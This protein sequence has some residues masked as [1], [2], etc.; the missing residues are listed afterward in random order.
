MISNGSVVVKRFPGEKIFEIMESKPD[1]A[2]Y[3][4]KT[5]T[6]RLT[7]ANDLIVDLVTRKEKTVPKDPYFIQ[8]WANYSGAQQGQETPVATPVKKVVK[9]KEEKHIV[10][11]FDDPELN[12]LPS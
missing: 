3:L 5:I 9:V 6:S 10:Q 1:I 8:A 2:K 4:I 11:V 12:K 7:H